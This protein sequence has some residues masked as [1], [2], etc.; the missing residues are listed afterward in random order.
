MK[1]KVVLSLVD[2]AICLELGG[3]NMTAGQLGLGHWGGSLVCSTPVAGARVQIPTNI[4]WTKE[5]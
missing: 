5:P 3:S 1:I 2:H 4:V